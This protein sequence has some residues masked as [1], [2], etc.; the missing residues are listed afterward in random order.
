VELDGG[1]CV[2][3][4]CH[5]PKNAADDNLIPRGGGAFI[6]EVDGNL[7]ACKGG[8]IVTVHWQGKFRGPDF[9]PIS[10][11][12]RTDKFDRLRDKKG[13]LIPTVTARHLSDSAK[14]EIIAV[15]RSDD[16]RTLEALRGTRCMTPIEVARALGWHLKNGEPHKSK[17]HAVLGRLEKA[18]LVKNIDRERYVLTPKGEKSP[19]M[20]QFEARTARQKNE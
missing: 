4:N 7:T 15:A 11:E 8:Q 3:V 19:R 12:L 5:P 10:F 13:R 17:A 1:P 2:L 18:K 14:E 20:N 6:A 16:D 9:A